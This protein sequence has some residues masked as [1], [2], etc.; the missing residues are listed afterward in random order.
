LIQ[1]GIHDQALTA[2]RISEILKRPE[3]PEYGLYQSLNYLK[4]LLVDLELKRSVYN[5]Q[6]D[7]LLGRYEEA[8]HVVQRIE[9]QA[10][11]E[12]GDTLSRDLTRVRAE[13][14]A[15]RQ[16]TREAQIVAE[17]DRTIESLIL[18]K[19]LNRTESLES[20]VD[21]IQ[22]PIQGGIAEVVAAR[23]NMSPSDSAVQDVW[24]RRPGSRRIKHSYDEASP[25]AN[26][27]GLWRHRELWAALD[28]AAR[29]KLL[30]G[31]YV[32]KY[33][34]VLSRVDKSCYQC[35][36]LGSIL[37][38]SRRVTCPICRGEGRIRVLVFR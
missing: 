12:P 27:E 16:L 31:I 5:V 11:A 3:S 25:L 35:G 24:A 29:F 18:S 15:L 1:A 32:E 14:V 26:P 17:W 33:M 6:Q 21:F 23:V 9:E 20:A 13:L 2:L 22:G 28:S 36:S 37:E 30:K 38:R 8:L 4:E 34:D 7:L 10:G 19:A